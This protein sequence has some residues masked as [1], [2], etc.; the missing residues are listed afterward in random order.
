MQLPSLQCNPALLADQNRVRTIETSLG[1]IELFPKQAYSEKFVQTVTSI[2]FAFETQS[3][4][5]AIASDRV[6]DFSARPNGL[7]FLPE[8]CDVFSESREGGEYLKIRLFPSL[9]SGVNPRPFSDHID[10]CAV[11]SAHQLR[12][13]VLSDRSLSDDNQSMLLAVEDITL[14]IAEIATKRLSVSE[15]SYDRTPGLSLKHLRIVEDLIEANIDNKLTVSQLA[16]HCHLSVAYF[17]RAFKKSAGQSPHAYV[18]ERRLARARDL[19]Q[20][21]KQD[22]TDI[23]LATGFASHAHMT[24]AFVAKL[25]A[26]PSRLR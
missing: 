8:G 19:L 5:H 16:H 20:N 17:A 6:R 1:I 14:R 22:L 18:L 23:A 21:T 7:A 13:L 15:P 10:A 4:K 11:R 26:V 12:R 24:S 9:M 3:G 2:G 25:G